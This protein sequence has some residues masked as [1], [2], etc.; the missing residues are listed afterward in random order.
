MMQGPRFKNGSAQMCGEREA[1]EDSP[2]TEH[3]PSKAWSGNASTI[4]RSFISLNLRFF[5]QV[6]QGSGGSP[7]PETKDI[8]PHGSG[9]YD[10]PMALRM[11]HGEYARRR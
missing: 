4:T 6:R 2:P 3:S 10:A 9:K 5:Y 8:E 7:E 1:I 11:D